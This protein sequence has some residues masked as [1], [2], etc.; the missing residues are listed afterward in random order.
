VRRSSPTPA[1]AG[2]TRRIR[3]SE[4]EGHPVKGTYLLVVA[5]ALLG[6]HFAAHAGNVRAV[7]TISDLLKAGGMA[8][9]D[10][11][12]VSGY[13]RVG[14]GG[15]GMFRWSAA[16]ASGEDG[17]TVFRSAKAN[18]G[19]WVRTLDEQ[20]PINVRWFGVWGDGT[21]DDRAR[22]Q[23]AIYAARDANR[24]LY[25]PKGEYV[26]DGPLDFTH[27]GGI[28]IRGEDPGN[29]GIAGPLGISRLVFR[30]VDSVGADFSGSSYGSIR[31]LAFCAVGGVRPKA[32][33]LLARGEAGYGSD[34]T[35][36]NCNFAS[37]SVASIF[38][39]SAEVISLIDCR[40]NCGGVGGFVATGMTDYGVQSPFPNCAFSKGIS[41][42][43]WTIL[44]G[45]FT[46]GAAACIVF[47]GRNYS[48]ADASIHGTY[49]SC[50]GANSCAVRFRGRCENVT[51]S[52]HR[53]EVP[54]PLQANQGFCQ[55]DQA[56]V[57]GLSIRGKMSKGP[58]VYGRGNM[59]GSHISS[60]NYIDL[61]G[62]LVNCDVT[63]YEPCEA[64]GGKLPVSTIS[65]KATGT[66][67]HLYDESLR[68]SHI[69]VGAGK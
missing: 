15:G 1:A 10:V 35:F 20:S 7:D 27:W 2:R 43:Q 30:S 13:L 65:G 9:G 16:D 63:I 59:E 24:G 37:G 21:H 42:T 29:A 57:H 62:D 46:T 17:G 49:F 67:F 38:C 41:L 55:L 3:I 36:T 52:G 69:K 50:D 39:F 25:I 4:L 22:I 44:G 54:T 47:D 56:D 68:D 60:S 34:L 28:S 11:A 31:G 32:T 6:V 53:C 19:R 58:I 51:F 61:S 23:K 12:I 33:V 66:R 40:V 45:E 18:A 8:E 64:N 5:V 48:L 26:C 14:D